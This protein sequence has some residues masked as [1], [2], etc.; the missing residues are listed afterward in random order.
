MKFGTIVPPVNMRRLRSLILDMMSYFQDGGHYVISQKAS[1]L[2]R[3]TSLARCLCYSIWSTAHSYLA[4]YI[5]HLL[6][7]TNLQCFNAIDGGTR[8]DDRS[9]ESSGCSAT[10]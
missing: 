10:I 9:E 4:D 5:L 1:S 8:K 3:V 7:Y 2:P 6:L